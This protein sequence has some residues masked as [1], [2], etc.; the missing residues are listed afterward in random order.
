MLDVSR[1]R[2]G[3]L[4][5][6]PEDVD[7]SRLVRDLLARI[8]KDPK[9]S[10]LVVTCDCEPEIFVRGDQLRLEQVLANLVTNAIKYGGDKPIQVTLEKS[11][12]HAVL[13]VADSGIGIAKE[14]QARIFEPFERAVS[15]KSFGG[16]GLGL[17]IVRQIVK[18][19]G[20]VIRVESDVGKGAKFTVELPL[21]GRHEF[22]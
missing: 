3:K 6:K 7:L 4:A 12:T 17:Y 2:T 13:A 18:M 5:L 16:I 11:E 1:I 22:D 8:A 15:I 19:H 21:L 10:K 9:N 14:H 20:G